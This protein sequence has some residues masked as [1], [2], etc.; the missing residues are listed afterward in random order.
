ME[1]PATSAHSMP[2]SRFNQGASCSKRYAV[3]SAN[4]LNTSTLRLPG[5]YGSLTLPAMKSR[6]FTSLASRSGVTA[7]A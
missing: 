2:S 4:A 6:S 1:L 5:L 7:S 3:V